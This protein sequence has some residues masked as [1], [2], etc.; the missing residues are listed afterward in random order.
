V[1]VG[2]GKVRSDDPH[3]TVRLANVTKA[4]AGRAGGAKQGPLRV[5]LVGRRPL[6]KR[7]R[8]LDSAAPSLV[9]TGAHRAGGLR[10]ALATL[11]RQGIQ[12]LLVEGGATI[13]GAFIAAGLV[14]RVAFFF[15]PRLLGAGIPIAA[16]PGRAM[17]QALRLGPLRARTVG[18]DLLITG[19]VL[20]AKRSR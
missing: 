14:D 20:Q 3:L 10:R 16:G 7:A 19:D 15:A 17:E 6:P 9:L 4:R 11:A 5:V 13:H 2:A 12:S 1:L 18:E 8:V